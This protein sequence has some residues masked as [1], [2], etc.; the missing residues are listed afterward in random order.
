MTIISFIERS[1]LTDTLI[2]PMKQARALQAFKEIPPSARINVTAVDMDMDQDNNDDD[3]GFEFKD[4]D[5]V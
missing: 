1:P 3:M 2:I 5:K 4:L